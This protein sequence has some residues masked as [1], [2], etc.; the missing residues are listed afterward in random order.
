M[1]KNIR[2]KTLVES[3]SLRLVNGN[4]SSI[5][6]AFTSSGLGSTG[7]ALSCVLPALKWHNRLPAAADAF[8]QVRSEAGKVVEAK[9]W[10]NAEGLLLWAITQSEQKEDEKSKNEYRLFLLSLC[11]CYRKASLSGTSAD[12]G[13]NGI[14]SLLKHHGPRWASE[15]TF[16][17]SAGAQHLADVLHCY[18]EAILKLAREYDTG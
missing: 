4:V 15:V 14:S 2:G 13:V 1:V 17:T 6:E 9:E 8:S 12:I 11:E 10:E 7:D 16:Q 3:P 5:L 18:Q